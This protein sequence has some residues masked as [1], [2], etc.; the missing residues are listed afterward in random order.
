[1]R[2]AHHGDGKIVENHVDAILVFDLRLEVARLGGGQCVHFAH[3]FTLLVE[4]HL[5]L[6]QRVVWG[7]GF[8]V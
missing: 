7:L 2:A 5:Q 3:H 4:A 6:V 1:M 8:R